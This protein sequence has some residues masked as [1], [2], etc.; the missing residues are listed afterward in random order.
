MVR[1]ATRRLTVK[2][3]AEGLFCIAL[4]D[5]SLALVIKVHTGNADALACAVHALVEEHFPGTL[6]AEWD[7]N[8]VK[9]VAGLA[10]GARTLRA[11]A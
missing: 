5:A 11:S 9:N 1:G 2:I 10:V 8:V 6:P 7:W 4:P 3:G